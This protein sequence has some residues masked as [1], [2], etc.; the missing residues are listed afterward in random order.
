MTMKLTANFLLMN[1]TKGALRYA[2]RLPNGSLAQYPNSPGAVI[3]TL[4]I[5]KSAFEGSPTSNY[6]KAISIQIIDS[7]DYRDPDHKST[8]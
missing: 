3:G 1:E 5:R 4:Y 8:T 6:P 7:N 2:E